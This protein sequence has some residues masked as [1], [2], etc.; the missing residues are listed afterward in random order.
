VTLLFVGRGPAAEAGT[1]A[2]AVEKKPKKGLLDFVAEAQQHRWVSQ[3]GGE[4]SGKTAKSFAKLHDSD[5]NALLQT[6]ARA[7]AHA[8]R[9]E[10]TAI[11]AMDASSGNWK[12]K[13]LHLDELPG[14]KPKTR[15]LALLPS[16]RFR[17]LVAAELLM[18]RS[19]SSKDL[20]L[21]LLTGSVKAAAVADVTA[22]PA[23]AVLLFTCLAMA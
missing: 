7:L 10:G 23:A 18:T 2:E 9:Q 11:R 12:D 17:M 4:L 8:A 16:G 15:V 1:E 20:N 5:G 22:M 6:H 13:R 3:D 14:L 19:Y 21:N